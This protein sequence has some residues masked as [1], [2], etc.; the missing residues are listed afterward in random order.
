ML[1]SKSQAG[2][3]ADSEQMPIVDSQATITQ[4]PMCLLHN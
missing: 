2:T 3:N 1:N 4:N